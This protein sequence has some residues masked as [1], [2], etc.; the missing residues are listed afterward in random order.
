MEI[1]SCRISNQIW[2]RQRSRCLWLSLVPIFGF[3]AFLTMGKRSG[4]RR[5]YKLGCIYGVLM[6]L[7]YLAGW[8]LAVWIPLLLC[9]LLLMGIQVACIVHTLSSREEYLIQLAE[10]EI[11]APPRN[12]LVND[13]WWRVRSQWWRLWAYIPCFGG[14]ST[15]FIARRMGKRW[16]K[17][18]SVI[19]SWYML[20]T[21]AAAAG[22]TE[23]MTLWKD[24]FLALFVGT[25][26]ASV[27]LFSV[28]AAYYREDYLDAMA[29]IWQRDCA[30]N[31]DLGNGTFRAEKSFYMVATWMPLIGGL[32]LSLG[33]VLGKH[34]RSIWMG[35][36]F[37]FGNIILL[38]AGTNLTE[39]VVEEP[40]L[41]VLLDTISIGMMFVF[42]VMQVLP[43]YYATLTRWDVL[44]YKAQQI[45]IYRR[46]YTEK[47]RGYQT[48]P[49]P[50]H[51]PVMP[52]KP[53]PQQKRCADSLK[54]TQV[55][56]Y[57]NQCT[58]E[59]LMTLPGVSA[60]DAIQAMN[61]RLA[62]GRFDSIDEFLEVLESKPHFVVQ[63]LPRVQLDRPQTQPV[64]K[65]K[66]N[67]RR[68]IDV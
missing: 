3:Y 13:R 44:R 63:I 65:T 43:F 31:P 5:Y 30:A 33:G 53:G 12:P 37:F 40:I 51:S 27:I 25:G 60:A 19:C 50:A 22:I 26:S 41:Q 15:Y 58:R 39:L 32:G 36:L 46:K 29:H 59:E 14:L 20:L 42:V 8:F 34:R 56:I 49:A 10:A 38:Y 21:C 9:W 16:L 23:D 2:R 18:F 62:H 48:P 55:M 4:C 6:V 52:S 1:I 61:Y 47:L 54:S 17:R 28:L 7:C 45:Q 57:V 67:S 24:V 68:V 35:L 66:G 64:Q 11:K